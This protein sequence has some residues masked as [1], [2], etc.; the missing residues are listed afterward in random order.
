MIQILISWI[1]AG[2]WGAFLFYL[3]SLSYLPGVSSLPFNDKV[4]H[5]IA[6][7]ILGLALGWGGWGTAARSARRP[8]GALISFIL[9]LLL[10]V[11]YGASDEWHQSFVPGR[12]VSAGD[13]AADVAGILVGLLVI[14]WLTRRRTGPIR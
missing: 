10:G 12:D 14:R 1:P 3:S 2:A 8:G 13:F 5:F 9:P 7:T 4:A 6:Y 11:A